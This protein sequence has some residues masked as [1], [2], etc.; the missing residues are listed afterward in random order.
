MYC[1]KVITFV[2]PSAYMLPSKLLLLF[3][4]FVSVSITSAQEKKNSSYPKNEFSI[5]WGL[6]TAKEIGAVGGAIFSLIPAIIGGTQSIEEVNTTGALVLS[7]SYSISQ[8]FAVGVT[9]AREKMTITYRN[10][11][12]ISYR[13]VNAFMVNFRYYYVDRPAFRVHSGFG[14]GFCNINEGNS[15][16]QERA[17]QLNA[18]GLRFGEYVGISTELGFG[19]EGILKLG[20][21]CR[22]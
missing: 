12:E 10:P 8:K 4:C 1:P 21:F 17:A 20:A 19:D 11:K 9:Y 2:K 13:K 5:A 18:I 15:T 3:I 16:T 6:G 14:L 7:H 22:F